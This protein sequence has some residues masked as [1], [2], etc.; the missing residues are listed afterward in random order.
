MNQVTV[1]NSSVTSNHELVSSSL[2][3]ANLN[4]F[5]LKSKPKKSL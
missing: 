5:H 4:V 3:G 1:I 2:T